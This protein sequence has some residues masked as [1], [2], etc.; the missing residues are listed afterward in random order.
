MFVNVCAPQIVGDLETMSVTTNR[1]QALRPSF[2][3]Y[4][5]NSSLVEHIT[6]CGTFTATEHGSV[7]FCK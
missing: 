4:A 5:T 2:S 7:V 6:I 1:R 3:P